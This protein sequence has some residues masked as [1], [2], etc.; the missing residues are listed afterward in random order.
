MRRRCYETTH[1]KYKDYG[2]QGIKTSAE[3]KESFDNFC[4]DML[5]SYNKHVKEYGETDTTLD[6]I[7]VFGNYCKENCRWAD[8]T[9]QAYNRAMNSNNT[10]GRTGVYQLTNGNW[11]AQIGYYKQNIILAYDVD[12]ETACKAR[13]EGELK[14]YGWKKE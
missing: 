4:E 3:W 7:D 8:L 11:K 9:T 10:S 14:Y 12:Y 1:N 13:E 2:A 6:R 5:E